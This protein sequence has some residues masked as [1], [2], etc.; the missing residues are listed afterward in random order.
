MYDPL[1]ARS[2]LPDFHSRAKVNVDTPRGDIPPRAHPAEVVR[3]PVGRAQ[4]AIPAVGGADFPR[5]EG[6]L[7]SL[8]RTWHSFANRRRP[9]E[10][11][12]PCE[13]FY[14]RP[15]SPPRCSSPL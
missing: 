10:A 5:L 7:A 6:A 12:R 1:A 8:T 3:P 2:V 14:L 11:A 15:P 9:S 13:G 4:L